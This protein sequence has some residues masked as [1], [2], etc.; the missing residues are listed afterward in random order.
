MKVLTVKGLMK[1]R[2]VLFGKKK[3]SRKFFERC[4]SGCLGTAALV[5]GC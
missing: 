3:E 4:K 2:L 5:S 1:L